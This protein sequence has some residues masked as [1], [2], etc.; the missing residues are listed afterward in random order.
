MCKQ[1]DWQV[2]TDYVVEEELLNRNTGEQFQEMLMDARGDRF[3]VL[4]VWSLD[5]FIRDWDFTF[6][7]IMVSLRSWNVQF[8][9]YK[10]PFLDTAGPFADFLAPLFTWLARQ[11]SV[12][13]TR[14]VVEME[15]EDA[16]GK[17]ILRFSGL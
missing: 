1:L 8:Y 14:E 16:K 9:S 3:D 17:R 12:P 5:H 13:N 10:E 11:E 15:M 7:H 4:L 2:A 6:Y